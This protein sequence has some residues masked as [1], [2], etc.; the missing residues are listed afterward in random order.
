MSI[1]S[2]N[3][4]WNFLNSS[5]LIALVTLVAG[6]IAFYLYDKQ[7]R[8][9]KKDAANIILLEI[10]SAER[11]L[12]QVAEDVRAE[13]LPNKYLLPT[14]SWSRY[15]YYFVRD[16]DRDEWDLITEFYNN[17]KLFDEAVRYNSS[18][19][20]KNEEQIRVN[21]LRTPA[22]YVKEYI[23]GAVSEDEDEET[24]RLE[25]IFEKS[26]KFQ[27]TFLSRVGTLFYSP[28]KPLTDGTE[29]FN[30]INKLLSQT[31]VGTKLKRQAGLKV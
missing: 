19:F 8:D 17:A 24:Q 1:F 4:V 23:D 21:M 7:K 22:E 16:L 29:A 25:K 30:N 31:S 2:W 26:Q 20:Q 27:K 18:M 28:Q 15:K 5:F 12:S 3:S 6:A 14:E 13:K 10:Q 9:S 11:I